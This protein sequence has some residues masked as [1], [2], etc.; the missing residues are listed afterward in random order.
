MCRLHACLVHKP[1]ARALG[2]HVCVCV[3]TRTHAARTQNTRARTP[4]SPYVICDCEFMCDVGG[5]GD[6]RRHCGRLGVCDYMCEVTTCDCGT[7][8]HAEWTLTHA[9]THTNP[10]SHQTRASRMCACRA[11]ERETER[12]SCARM[13]PQRRRRRRRATRPSGA[14][15]A[16]FRRGW[17]PDGHTT[18]SHRHTHTRTARPFNC[19]IRN[20][21]ARE[22]HQQRSQQNGCDDK[23]LADEPLADVATSARCAR[24]AYAA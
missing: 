2:E 16:R 18:Y 8:A 5:V 22:I 17:R 1:I 20:S 21:F 4:I 13:A 19:H 6:G 3:H 14:N 10:H 11:I 9:C 7:R 15:I 23:R 24:F 12:A